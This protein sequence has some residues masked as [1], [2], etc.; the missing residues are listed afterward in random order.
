LPCHV[1]NAEDINSIFV[2]I[3]EAHGRLDILLKNAAANPYFG[4]ILGTDL[5]VFRKTVNHNVQ[6]YFVLSM[7][8]FRPRRTYQTIQA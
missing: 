4:D 8:A 6:G 1:G 2:H 7:Q 3:R 5:A